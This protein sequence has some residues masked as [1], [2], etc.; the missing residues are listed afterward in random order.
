MKIRSHLGKVSGTEF[1]AELIKVELRH[2]NRKM[3]SM[4]IDFLENPSP[5]KGSVYSY[6]ANSSLIADERKS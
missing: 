4:G 2:R 5:M 1:G 3:C 6:V